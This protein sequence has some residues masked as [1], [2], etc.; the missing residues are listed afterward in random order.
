LAHLQPSC[1]LLASTIVAEG[2][3]ALAILALG[4]EEAPAIGEVVVCVRVNIL[5]SHYAHRSSG[6]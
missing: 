3:T 4:I 5:Y 1:T 2:Q 6:E